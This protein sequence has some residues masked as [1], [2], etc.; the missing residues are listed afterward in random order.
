[1]IFFGQTLGNTGVISI[2]FLQATSRN[3]D[4]ASHE[5]YT[6]GH[7]IIIFNDTCTS[8]YDDLS[9]CAIPALE[10]F[11]RRHVTAPTNYTKRKKLCFLSYPVPYIP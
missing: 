9:S 8:R 4:A 6:K 7:G 3:K 5:S 11:Y 2:H 10:Q 1:M